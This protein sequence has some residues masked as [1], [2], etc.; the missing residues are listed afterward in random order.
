MKKLI[1][2]G[3]VESMNNLVKN[4][5]INGNKKISILDIDNDENNIEININ[6]AN[7]SKIIINC[8]VLSNNVEKKYKIN[9]FHESSNSISEC[10][11][12]GISKN[13]KIKFEINTTINNGT[14]NN[15]CKQEIRGFL[16]TKNSMIKGNPNL[17]IDT[18]KIKAS[19]KLSIGKVNENH[20]YYLMSR[21]IDKKEAM[22][23]LTSS[24]FFR[25][26]EMVNEN[27]QEELKSEIKSY[28]DKL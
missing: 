16:L 3:M 15:N 22:Y 1:L 13:N 8:S 9:I 17:I 18:N 24:I 28:Y 12:N 25:H 11:C 10:Y 20:L 14:E 2:K 5:Y 19:H 21:G 27:R 23:L 26:F 7:N 4:Y 6:V